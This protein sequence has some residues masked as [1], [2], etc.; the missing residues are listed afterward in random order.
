M[1]AGLQPGFRLPPVI[2]ITGPC[3]STV[4]VAVREV[5]E[6]LL[7]ASLA[8]HVIVCVLEQPV[9]V[10]VPAVEVTGT[11]PA[12][13]IL[14]EAE[15]KLMLSGLQPGFRLPP[16]IVITGPCVSTVQVAVREVDEELLQASLAFH[17]IVCVLEQPVVVIVPAV[18]VTGTAPAQLSLAEAE[19]KLM[20]A[21]LQPGFRLP[22]VIVITGPSTST[23][24][25][26]VREVDEEL[27]QASLA[28][29]VIVCVLEQPVVVIVPAVEVTALAPEQLSLAEAEPKLMLVGLQPGF[30]LPPVIVITGPC[31]STVHVAV[32]EVDEELLQA[33]LAFHVIVCVLEQPVVVIVPAVEVTALAPEQ[34][35]LAEAEP[36]LT[37]PGL[38]P[39]FRLPPVI[40]ITGPCV[41][42]V[43]VAV[44]VVD[45]DCRHPSIAFQ[46]MVCVRVQPLVV[47][48]PAVEVSVTAPAQLS[49]PEAEP[50]LMAPSGLQPGLRLPPVIE[51][52][53]GVTSTVHVNV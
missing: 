50:K 13:L 38:Q 45:E 15:P 5:D 10:I 30:R 51:I 6:E 28:F 47:I 33:S 19:P 39:G 52:V 53:G 48:E 3:V 44:R 18:E 34:L 20:L 21:G 43:H 17:V 16:V 8:F 32:R 41:S 23:V 37:V 31:V 49:E 9:V 11:A 26:A 25:V 4:Q 22:P 36:K 35:S 27:L 29:H 42:T 2:V 7:Q 1:L 12:Q 14:A 46:V 40:V 24:Q